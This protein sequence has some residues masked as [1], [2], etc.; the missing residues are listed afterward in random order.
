MIVSIIDFPW[1]FTR[2]LGTLSV[3]G[4]ILVPRPAAISIAIIKSGVEMFGL[5]IYTKCSRKT[6]EKECSHES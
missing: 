3:K 6:L 2:G 5:L 1:T 4:L